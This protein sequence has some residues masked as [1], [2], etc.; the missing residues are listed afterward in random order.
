VRTLSLVLFSFYAG[1]SFAYDPQVG[2]KPL[3][4]TAL[5]VY[6][7]CFT[8]PD[9]ISRDA[10]QNRITEGDV[11]MDEG[12]KSN[13]KDSLLLPG[14]SVFYRMIRPFNWHFYNAE[15]AAS[16]KVGLVDQSMAHLWENLNK[17]F[18][19]AKRNHD[20]LLFLGGIIHLVE[21]LTVPAHVVPVY[22]GPTAIGIMGPI[23]FK[24][25]VKYMQDKSNAYSRKIVDPIDA[26]PP[27]V[28]RLENAFLK[29]KDI[30]A[31]VSASSASPDEVRTATAKFT[32]DQ[33]GVEI[34]ECPGV[35][36]QAFW[37]KPIGKEYFGRYNIADNNPMFGEAGVL[38]SKTATCTLTR[39]ERRYLDFVFALH[40]RAI[41]SDM[42]VLYWAS[43]RMGTTQRV[44]FD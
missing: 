29:S 3:L 44:R 41:E 39:L 26:I 18:S 13:F 2:H 8:Q 27:D 31:R 9:F 24:P 10:N 30:C 7:E 23:R 11:A 1:C 14:A 42:Q 28:G 36:W 21:D 37:L 22:H 17:N 33:L 35:T 40:M 16:S 20:R 19:L 43:Q 25:L 4:T 32:L 12:L 5:K 38:S 34:P 6:N 15:R